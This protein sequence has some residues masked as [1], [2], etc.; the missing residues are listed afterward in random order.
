MLLSELKNISTYYQLLLLLLLLLKHINYNDAIIKMQQRYF[1]VTK[2]MSLTCNLRLR[3]IT[4]SQP[5]GQTVH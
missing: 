1:T 3:I 4:A 2:Y 5:Y